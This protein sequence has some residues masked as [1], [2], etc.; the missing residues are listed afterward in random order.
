MIYRNEDSILEQI[1]ESKYFRPSIMRFKI[2]RVIEENAY[3]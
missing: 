2:L 1:Y 3:L